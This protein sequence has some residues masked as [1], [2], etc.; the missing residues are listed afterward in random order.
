MA[1]LQS[2]RARK[3]YKYLLLTKNGL[4]RPSLDGLI[5]FNYLVI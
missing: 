1:V 2:A 3:R 4:F 5:Q